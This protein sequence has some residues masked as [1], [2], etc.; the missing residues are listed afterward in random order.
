MTG[1]VERDKIIFVPVSCMTKHFKIISTF[2]SLSSMTDVTK[3]G[4]MGS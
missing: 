4:K 3:I 1:V 2:I